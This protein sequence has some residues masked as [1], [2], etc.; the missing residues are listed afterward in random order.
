MM[1]VGD[2]VIAYDHN[3]KFYM[4]TNLRNPHY[5]PE[6]SV[7][8]SLL[9]FMITANGLEE[10]LLGVVVGKE[11]PDCEEKKTMLVQQNAQ[12]KEEL[13]AVEDNI[14]ALLEQSGPDILDEDTLIDAL[15]ESGK[16]KTEIQAKME[17][18]SITEKETDA[19]RE[20]YRPCAYRSQLLFFCVGDLGNVDPMYQYS[21]GWFK[22]TFLSSIV[23]SQRADTVLER[24]RYINDH[25]TYNLW[26]N[27]CRGI[28]EKDKLLFTMTLVVKLLQ[29]FDKLDPL[30]WRFI[31]AG[32]PDLNCKLPNPDPEWI[33]EKMWVE[34]S[35]AS[36]CLE[37]FAGLDEDFVRDVAGFKKYFDNDD[38]DKI[39]PPGVWADRLGL[40]QELILLRAIR[41]DKI[42]PKMS[43]FIVEAQGKKYIVPPVFD[44]NVSYQNATNTIPIVFILSVGADPAKDLFA[45]AESQNMMS[46]T[47]YIS[48]GQGQDKKAEAL[49][50]EGTR[51]GLWILLQNCH[52]YKSWMV[53]LAKRVEMLDPDTVHRDFRLWLTSMPTPFFPVSI[54]ENSV[55]LV[56][57]PPAGLQANLRA[58]YSGFT[59][60]YLQT[61]DKPDTWRKLLWSLSLF[62]AVLLERKKY[63]PLGF[64]I[65]YQF[66]QGDCDVGIGQGFLFIESYDEVPWGSIAVLV[67]D[68]NY[69][70]RV[71]DGNDRVMVSALVEK[72]ACSGVL[73]DGHGFTS[74]GTYQSFSADTIEKTL[75]EIEKLPTDAKPEAFG[76]HPNAEIVYSTNEGATVLA[77]ILSLQPRVSAG[78][79]ASREDTIDKMCVDLMERVPGPYD[80]EP[81]MK[82]YPVTYTEGMNTVLQQEIG[83]YNGLLAVMQSSLKM[84]RKAL[85]GQVVMSEELDACSSSM[86]DLQIPDMWMD[87]GYPSLMPLT[88][89]SN[90]LI[91]RLDFLN[92][93]IEKGIPVHYWL[94]GFFFPQAFLTGT[95]QNYARKHQVA[96][97]TISFE[98]IMQ[99][100][101]VLTHEE[102]TEKPEQG[103]YIHGLFLEGCRWDSDVKTL[104]ESR[105]K[106]LY[107][108]FV[109]MHLNPVVKRVVPET[110]IYRCPLYKVLSRTG[111]LSTT[112]HST[113]YV[114]PLEIPSSHPQPHWIGRGVAL[115]TQLR[116]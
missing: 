51:A 111:T 80:L 7:K 16:M 26:D 106:E 70:G 38:P 11:R 46:K 71:T 13:T 64:N 15:D 35:K 36:D 33:T 108:L 105:P 28:M 29:G 67:T 47:K 116:Y 41:P 109:P 18:A 115:F 92:K 62:H 93:W 17:E 21:L 79:G 60:E 55:K 114:C 104:T 110:G 84:V 22:N 77:T 6:V 96:I 19:A 91:L 59:D 8:V 102:F 56:N 112:G 66:T 24:M 58:V 76:F 3:F 42:L 100:G 101:G 90:D 61:S 44:L 48:L 81:I 25:F 54:L 10:Q 2:S 113:N 82:A 30:E 14:L 68:C 63:G 97:D 74:S 72:Y 73:E 95:L 87:K 5:P 32:P 31:L 53:V 89:W 4:T 83:R 52:L 107:T 98:T 57:Q 9:N 27:I 78:A 40:F 20:E 103:C 1:K 50:D 75:A 94:P 37:K 88:G 49:L 69:G 65:P 43:Q 99:P 34:V 86:F 85:V 45:F 23:Q 12:M 39:S